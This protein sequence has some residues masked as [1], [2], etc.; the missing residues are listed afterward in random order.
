MGL[1]GPL[2]AQ[3]PIELESLSLLPHPA[4]S[5]HSISVCGMYEA[6][7]D[8]GAERWG[9]GQLGDQG[10]RR[11]HGSE[12]QAGVP[13]PS[14]SLAAPES[15]SGQIMAPALAGCFHLG[16]PRLSLGSSDEGD[17]RRLAGQVHRWWAQP[18]RVAWDS[19]CFS[20]SLR[21]PI[22]A[23]SLVQAS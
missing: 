1:L 13:G 9:W 16:L 23:A 22:R 6:R 14:T 7:G 12:A 3:N 10:G 5:R 15:P 8:A 21:F 4:N 17:D 18:G 20:L 2:D 11:P 19:G